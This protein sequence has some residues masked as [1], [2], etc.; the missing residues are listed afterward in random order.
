M[1]KAFVGLAPAKMMKKT[2][3]E[4]NKDTN[5][6]YLV[7]KRAVRETRRQAKLMERKAWKMW[8]SLDVVKFSVLETRQRAQ[9]MEKQVKHMWRKAHRYSKWLLKND[10]NIRKA[11]RSL[12]KAGY[13]IGKPVRK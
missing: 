4:M 12:A 3:V 11:R 7:V 6:A 2:E 8:R 10:K 5:E 1:A 13:K 9:L